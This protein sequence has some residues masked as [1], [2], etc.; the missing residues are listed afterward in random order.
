MF[1]IKEIKDHS[2]KNLA[3]RGKPENSKIKNQKCLVS[4]GNSKCNPFIKTRPRVL[5]RL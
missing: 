1:V 4:L 3:V 5:K 2:I